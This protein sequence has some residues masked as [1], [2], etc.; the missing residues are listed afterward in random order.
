MDTLTSQ[1][2]RL[3]SALDITMPGLLLLLSRVNPP[4]LASLL[5]T[6]SLDLSTQVCVQVCVYVCLYVC[7]CVYVCVLVCVCVMCVHV[8]LCK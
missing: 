4:Y 6:P 8:W 7:V 2:H 3:S 1:A 5:D